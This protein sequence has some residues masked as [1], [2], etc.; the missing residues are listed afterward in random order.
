[1]TCYL[2]L[3][4]KD[5]IDFKFNHFVKIDNVLYI[6]NHIYDYDI[7]SSDSTKVDLIT[8]TDVN[9]YIS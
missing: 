1:M 9:G 3:T 5:W 7:T 4:P 6:V 8:I 2:R